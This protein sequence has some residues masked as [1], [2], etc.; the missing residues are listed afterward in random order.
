[1]EAKDGGIA[2]SYSGGPGG[3]SQ[4]VSE[5]NNGSDVGGAGGGIISYRSGAGS[6]GGA[7]NPGGAHSDDGGRRREWNRRLINTLL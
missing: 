2:T 3:A 5:C 1:M 6:S 4:F 7:G